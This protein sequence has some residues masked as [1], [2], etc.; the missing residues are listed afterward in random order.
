[1][2]TKYRFE[3]IGDLQSDITFPVKTSGVELEFVLEK[4][5]IV[6]VNVIENTDLN[7]LPNFSLGNNG[8]HNLNLGKTNPDK[9][10]KSLKLA[11][12][13][14][15]IFGLREIKSDIVQIEWIPENEQEKSLLKV[16]NFTY[17][18]EPQNVNKPISFDLIARPFIAGFVNDNYEVA[19]SFFRQGKNDMREG[20]YIEAYYDFY[21]V[22]E[23]MYGGGKTK[24]FLIEKKLLE[25]T[26]L[27]DAIKLVKNDS[28]IANGLSRNHQNEF[29]SKYKNNE[30]SAIIKDIVN[31]RGFL[32]HHNSKHPDAWTPDKQESCHLDS[33]FLMYVTYNIVWHIINRYIYDEEIMK[34]YSSQYVEHRKGLTS[35]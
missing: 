17:K 24:N 7:H 1:M 20:K 15:S 22:L 4:E 18:T 31:K 28:G 32:H 6:A 5:K 11:E 35:P 12:G 33:I 30:I 19:L 16:F 29:N 23:S 21:F 13:L 3:I 9:F 25:S 14:L 8:I 10:K 27:I 34:T 2:K 26:E